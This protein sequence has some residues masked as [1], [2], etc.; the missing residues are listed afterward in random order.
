MNWEGS[1]MR[2]KRSF[3]NPTLFRKNLSRSWPLWGSVTALG[4]L[5]PLYLMLSVTRLGVGI[6]TEEFTSFLYE[7][8]AYFLPIFSFMYAVPVAVFVWSY[9]HKPRAV[10]MMHSLAIDRTGLFLTT[11]LSGFAMLLIP[12]VVVGGLLCLL[13]AGYGAMDAGSVLVTIAVVILENV[14]FFGM[15]TLCAMVTGRVAAAVAFYLILNFSVPVLDNLIGLLAA[16]FIFGFAGSSGDVASWFAPLNS[17]YSHVR[18]RYAE[19]VVSFGGF[20]IVVWYALAGVGMLALSWVL[21]RVRN[22]ESAGDVVAF[23]WLRPVFRFGVSVLGGLTLGRVLY[24]LFWLSIFSDGQNGKV[25]PMVAW[26]LAGAVVGYYAASMMLEKSLRVF[27]GSLKGVGVVCAVVAALCLCVSLDLFGLEKK[28][29]DADEILTVSICGTVEINCD[30]EKM[31]ALRD[32]MIAF[33]KAVIADKEHILDAE[34]LGFSYDGRTGYYWRPISIIYTLK[35][36][37]QLERYYYLPLSQERMA[38]KDTYD[39]ILNEIVNSPDVLIASVTMPE[40]AKFLYGYVESYGDKTEEETVFRF[41][42]QTWEILYRALEQDAR[43][44]NFTPEN[45]LMIGN[46]EQR[47]EFADTVILMVEYQPL[48]EPS[49]GYYVRYRTLHVYLQPS[50]EH[51]LDALI[52][53]GVLSEEIVSGWMA[54][55]R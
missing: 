32:R 5:I 12:Y 28:V 48:N 1:S 35:N 4:A 29:P 50:M 8:A 41:D 36:G 54:Q 10:G 23:S 52:S 31:P 33:H 39:G 14:L 20:S 22:S 18:P 2:S 19:D 44:G 40:D 11:G 42:N 30:A 34:S 9:L 3:F 25:I 47:E 16:D 17:L 45:G 49:E 21:Y 43:E 46:E 51:T 6:Q 53:T 24:S 38:Q 7:A 15:A 55:K 26:T 37:T 13:A 27:R